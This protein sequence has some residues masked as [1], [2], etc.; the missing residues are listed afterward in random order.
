[1][2]QKSNKRIVV[3]RVTSSKMDK[4]IVVMVEMR[5]RHP[6]IHKI[7]RRQKKFVAHDEQNLCHAGDLVKIE[8]SRPLSKTKRWKLVEILKKAEKQ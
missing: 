3:G 6:L 7:V 5:V 8:E 2:E 1:M 4:T